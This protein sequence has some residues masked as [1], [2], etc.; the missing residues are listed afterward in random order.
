MNTLPDDSGTKRGHMRGERERERYLYVCMYVYI[1][2]YGN[3]PPPAVPRSCPVQVTRLFPNICLC[4]LVIL[5]LW[6]S[7]VSF[8]MALEAS[9]FSVYSLFAPEISPNSWNVLDQHFP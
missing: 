1:Y 2:I 4:S 3:P 6:E 7:K 5:R 9:K 8:A